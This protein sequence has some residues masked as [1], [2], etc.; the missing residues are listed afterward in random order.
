MCCVWWLG[1]WVYRSERLQAISRPAAWLCLLASVLG[2]Y[3]YI[4]LELGQFGWEWVQLLVGSEW[5]RQLS[6]SR[7]F[8]TDYYLGLVLALHFVGLR[9]LLRDVE[10]IPG[11]FD[12]G[13]RYFAGATFSIYLFHQPLLCFYS[14]VFSFVDEG[15]SRYLLV[16]PMTLLTALALATVTEHRKQ[17][18]K[19][20]LE[21]LWPAGGLRLGQS[22]AT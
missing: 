18:W 21:R 10:A 9:V 16:V 20:G 8:P 14:A 15:L 5:H 13:V 3:A 22:P 11:W 7:Q 2:M 6:F 19:R 17:G 4:A 12:R 1:V